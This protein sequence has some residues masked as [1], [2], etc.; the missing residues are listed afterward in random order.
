MDCGRCWRTVDTVVGLPSLLLPPCCGL[1][2]PPPAFVPFANEATSRGAVVTTLG[3]PQTVGQY[4]FGVGLPDLDRDGDADLIALGTTQGMA[5]VFEN[6]GPG[7]FVNRTATAGLTGLTS[8]GGFA[9]ADLDADGDLDLVIS[10]RGDGPRFYRQTQP[11]LFEDATPGSGLVSEWMGR[12]VAISDLNGDGWPDVLLA[13]YAGLIR[14]TEDA[15]PQAFLN[16]GGSGRFIEASATCGLAEPAHNFMVA[17]ADLDRDGDPDLYASNDRAHIGP[18]FSSNRLLLNDRGAWSEL[19]DACG[20]AGAAFFSMGV[21]RGDFDGN[22][23]IDLLCTNLTAANQPLGPVHPLFMQVAPMVWDEQ[24]VQRGLVVGQN[25]TG[26]SVQAFDADHDG[27]LDVHIVHQ[28]TT[29]RFFRNH[30][31]SFT[32]W[33]SAAGLAGGPQTDFGS[34]LGDVDGDGALDLVTNPLGSPIRLFMN[35]EGHARPALRMRVE[36]EWPNVDAIGALVDVTVDGAVMP[37]EVACGG[38]GYLG[39]NDL[40]VHAGLGAS[41]QATVTVRWPWSG[42]TRTI[43][44]L[45]AGACWVIHPPERLMD[46]NGDWRVDALDAAA[47]A[48]CAMNAV[49]ECNCLVFD[50]DGDARIT[51]VDEAAFVVRLARARCDFDLDGDVDG[52][53][54]SRLAAGWATAHPLLDATGDGTVTGADLAELLSEWSP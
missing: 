45:P 9:A 8:P 7:T 18:I 48:N 37:L 6:T 3:T 17:P 50:A 27:D 43:T 30:Q 42:T 46:A 14:G 25:L 20:D 16:D 12:C 11:F 5:A 24:S 2:G 29:D 31:G 47:F 53:D 40:R 33:T 54:L 21:A 26:W 19:T 32:D 23:L 1:L 38:A 10:Q 34:A 4:G 28:A 52:A 39:M 13:N 51:P 49:V 15:H 36:G 22:G 44:G 41:T 35:R